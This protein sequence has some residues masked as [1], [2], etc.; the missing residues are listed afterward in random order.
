MSPEVTDN[1][2]QQGFFANLHES[3]SVCYDEQPFSS[4]ASW[5]RNLLYFLLLL[6]VISALLH[7]AYMRRRPT[8]Y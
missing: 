7:R 2:P 8:G 6:G 1:S 4:Q 3:A 5:K